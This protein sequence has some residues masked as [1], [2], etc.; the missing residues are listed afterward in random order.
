MVVFRSVPSFRDQL[1]ISGVVQVIGRDQPGEARQAKQQREKEQSEAEQ[2]VGY[3]I[4]KANGAD[5]GFGH[6]TQHRGSHW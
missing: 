2:P 4:G 3:R 6:I 5:L 1:R